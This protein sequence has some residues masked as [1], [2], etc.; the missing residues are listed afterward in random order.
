MK[1][2]R[3][4]IYV[5]CLLNFRIRG[6]KELKKIVRLS[7][8][9]R[10]HLHKIFCKHQY[11]NFPLM[12][13]LCLLALSW[14]K[15]IVLV[16]L[17]LAIQRLLVK[18][19]FLTI[20]NLPVLSDCQIIY[21]KQMFLMVKSK[22]SCNIYVTRWSYRNYNPFRTSSTNFLLK[23]TSIMMEVEQWLVWCFFQKSNL[24]HRWTFV[25]LIHVKNCNNRI[26]E[27]IEDSVEMTFF[28]I[29]TLIPR[30]VLGNETVK[31]IKFYIRK[32]QLV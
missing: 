8:R 24:V 11:W 5:C 4:K 30:H 27:N 23:W 15:N 3:I 29:N 10:T 12:S 17:S 21:R 18:N 13:H 19:C 26:T 14:W 7:P 28:T 20:Q 22:F 25:K 16:W 9:Q 31:N 32:A 1:I 2:C 6:L